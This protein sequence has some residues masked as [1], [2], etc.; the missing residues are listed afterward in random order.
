[1]NKARMKN[2]DRDLLEAVSTWW[3]G[4]LEEDPAICKAMQRIEALGGEH[5]DEISSLLYD[6]IG[7]AA[8][9][10]AEATVKKLL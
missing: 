7:R 3:E 1:M 4:K 10:E 5:A 6:I 8:D 9:M 2:A